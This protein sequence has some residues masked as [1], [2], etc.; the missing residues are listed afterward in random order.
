MVKAFVFGKFLPFHKGHQ[1]MIAFALTHCDLLT[2]LVCCSDKESIPS[3][4]RT[5]W[6]K[7]TFKDESRLDVVALNYR[8]ADYPN[9]SVSSQEVSRVWS[10]KFKELLPGHTLLITSEP[11]GN[12]VASFMCIK[13]ILFDLDRTKYPISATTIRNSPYNYWN[14]IPTAVKPYFLRKIILL[15]TESTGKTTLTEKLANY[16]GAASVLETARDVIK[17]SKNFQFDDLYK[18]AQLHAARIA[19]AETEASPLLFIDTDVHITKSYARFIFNQDLE[20]PD[21][22]T[23]QNKATLYLYLNN[24]VP[25]VQDGTRLNDEERNRLDSSHRIVL[26]EHGVEFLE[27]KGSWQERFEQS[28]KVIESLLAV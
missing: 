11:Y 17:D 14:Y 4:V 28:I 15:G 10:E 27:V 23:A 12:F 21:E 2:V 26:A 9:T 25:H 18:V 7:D 8:E 22:L 24:D 3:A 20:L 1:A 16:F 13:H 5:Q 19:T 6:I